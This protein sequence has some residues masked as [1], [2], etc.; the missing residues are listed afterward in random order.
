[1]KQMGTIIRSKTEVL[2]ETKRRL[3]SRNITIHFKNFYCVTDSPK[4]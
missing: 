3:T 4:H 1:M 2:A